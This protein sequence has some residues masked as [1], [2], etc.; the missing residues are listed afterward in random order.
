MAMNARSDAKRRRKAL[1]ERV[2]RAYPTSRRTCGC[3]AASAA[4][5]IVGKLI[6]SARP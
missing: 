1:A 3:I 6:T 4:Q 2:E 5:F